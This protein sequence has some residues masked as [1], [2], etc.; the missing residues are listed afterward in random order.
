MRAYWTG[1]QN[2]RIRLPT[3]QY[4]SKWPQRAS[5][6]KELAYGRIGRQ[7]SLSLEIK[8]SLACVSVVVD[9]CVRTVLR[10]EGISSVTSTVQRGPCS[11]LL[12][13]PVFVAQLPTM[14]TSL[15][16]SNANVH[17]V[18][19]AGGCSGN[20]TATPALPSC[21]AATRGCTGLADGIEERRV[22]S[23]RRKASSGGMRESFGRTFG[24]SAS[25]Y[26]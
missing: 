18:S 19:S 7:G 22:C 21:F 15:G 23:L 13:T 3:D 9:S 17:F 12:F 10:T 16:F 26:N 8:S 20:G 11:S 6:G 14:A 2:S 1:T 25:I 5:R 24:R 4:C